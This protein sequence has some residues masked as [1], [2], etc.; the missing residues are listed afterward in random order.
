MD[1]LV[2][3]VWKWGRPRMNG[4]GRL[5][6]KS[7]RFRIT[8]RAEKMKSS[9]KVDLTPNL[10]MNN[11]QTRFWSNAPPPGFLFGRK[12]RRGLFTGVASKRDWAQTDSWE[13]NVEWRSTS[14]QTPMGYP[15]RHIFH[16]HGV[17]GENHR[18]IRG[19]SPLPYWATVRDYWIFA[20]SQ[21]HP[22]D[23]R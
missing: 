11:S 5:A 8:L 3:N 22:I 20:V 17:G 1:I 12:W 23:L 13:F 2:R 18:I 21:I 4:Q 14:L 15:A 10:A 9:L 16:L 7:E 19:A 6:W